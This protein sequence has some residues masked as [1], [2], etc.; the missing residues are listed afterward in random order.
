MAEGTQPVERFDVLVV[1]TGPAGLTTANILGQAGV[2][3]LVVE[4]DEALSEIPKALFI[5]DEFFRLLAT[6][7]LGPQIAAHGVFPVQF[8]YYSP[9]G[10]RIGHVEAKISEHNYSRRTA[11]FQPEFERILHEG[12]LRFPSVSVRFGQELVGVSEAVGHVTATLRAPDGSVRLVEARYLVAADGS[13]STTRKLLGI[14]F[15]EVMS[16]GDRHIVVDVL[17]DPDQRKLALTKLGWRRNYVSL[18]SPNGGRRYETSLHDGEDEAA[19]LEDA[20]LARLLRPICDLERLTVIR[21]AVYTF[22]ARVARHLSK[23]RVFLVGDAAHVMPIFGSQGMNSGARDVKNLAWKVAAVVQ[24]KAD[25]AILATY[26]EERFEHLVDTIKVATANG[27]L[28]SVR[29]LPVTL[30]RDLVLGALS[31]VPAIRNWVREMRYI[32]K[33]YLKSGIVLARGTP[34]RSS[35]LGRVLPNPGVTVV[36]SPRLL[37]EVMGPGFA[38][39]GLDVAAGPPPAGLQHPLW[40]LVGVTRL[41]V[42]P[43]GSA[44]PAVEGTVGVTLADDRLAEVL[45]RHG[46]HWLVVRPDRIVAAVAAPAELAASTD[47]LASLLAPKQ[48]APAAQEVAL[49]V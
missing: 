17:N 45:S 21:K 4:K 20:T 34:D 49:A 43:A 13:H 5:D 28:Q 9:L 7:G 26:H 12:A 30:A 36:G 29:H 47:L 18:P 24:G 35:V 25:P 46:G 23:G 2:N 11:T 14:P 41:T 48:A 6:V 33:P 32:P 42:R 19:V 1:G 15:D 37:D 3:T 38:L 39:V 27:K 31:V 8:D 44:A 16:F 10:F 40:D 22:H